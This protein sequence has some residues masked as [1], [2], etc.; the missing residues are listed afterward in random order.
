MASVH[1]T[2]C[3]MNQQ[4]VYN[5]S[6]LVWE[7]LN[8]RG[9]P[10]TTAAPGSLPNTS[11]YPPTPS[12]PTAYHKSLTAPP[13]VDQNP[14]SAHLR[15]TTNPQL[16]PSLGLQTTYKSTLEDCQ[17]PP[18]VSLCPLPNPP[19]PPPPAPPPPPGP[20]TLTKT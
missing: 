6:A 1:K 9:L 16:P 19:P 11:W 4:D 15:F 8:I 13:K 7:L 20:V 2:Y 3:R 10:K 12:T 14:S 18:A 5:R 17:N